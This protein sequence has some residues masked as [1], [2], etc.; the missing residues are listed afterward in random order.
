MNLASAL[1]NIEVALDD[2]HKDA[3]AEFLA[4]ARQAAAAHNFSRHTITFGPAG[5]LVDGEEWWSLP[6]RRPHPAV[7]TLVEIANAA[8]SLTD[9][10]YRHLIGKSL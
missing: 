10:T 1:Q 7:T 6:S 8:N 3:A 9:T 5:L 2:A 4:A